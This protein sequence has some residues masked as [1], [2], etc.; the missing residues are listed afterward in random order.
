MC[1][2]YYILIVVN[3]QVN[4]KA[5]NCIYIGPFCDCLNSLVSDIIYP[6]YRAS[7]AVENFKGDWQSRY[8]GLKWSKI[9]KI[10]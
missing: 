7:A 5:R 4:L 10:V 1:M 6:N 9:A 8:S 2:Y 3:Q